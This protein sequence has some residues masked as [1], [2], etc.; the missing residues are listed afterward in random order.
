MI[1]CKIIE[2]T[3]KDELSER[4]EYFYDNYDIVDIKFS[5]HYTGALLGDRYVVMIIYKI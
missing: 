2:C 3:D 5:T 4:I 1:E